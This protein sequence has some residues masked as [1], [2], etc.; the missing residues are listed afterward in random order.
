MSEDVFPHFHVGDNTV[1]RIRVHYPDGQR[2]I[3]AVGEFTI[4]NG[5]LFAVDESGRRIATNFPFLL[6]QYEENSQV[7][8]ATAGDWSDWMKKHPGQPIPPLQPF[9]KETADAHRT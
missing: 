8:A 5:V 3:C 6:E 2:G 4:I 9:T 1:T 7:A